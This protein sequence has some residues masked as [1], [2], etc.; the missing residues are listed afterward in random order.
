MNRVP[1]GQLLHIVISY[2]EDQSYHCSHNN[3]CNNHNIM[4]VID[5]ITKEKIILHVL[6]I[7]YLKPPRRSV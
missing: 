1:G 3:E 5:I 2:F 7:I 4:I 6:I